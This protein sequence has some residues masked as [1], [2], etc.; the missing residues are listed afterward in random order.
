MALFIDDKHVNTGPKDEST[1]IPVPDVVCEY[2][3]K[4]PEDLENYSSSNNFNSMNTDYYKIAFTNLTD[5]I[6]G[7]FRVN[8]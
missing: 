3:G 2:Y 4:Q 8:F 5:Q 1:E 7:I 6:L